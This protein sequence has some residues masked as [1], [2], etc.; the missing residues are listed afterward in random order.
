MGSTTPAPAPAAAP[1]PVVVPTPV[2]T[3]VVEDDELEEIEPDVVEVVTVTAPTGTTYLGDSEAPT[4]PI[5]TP[6]ITGRSLNDATWAS[7][8]GGMGGMYAYDTIK[9]PLKIIFKQHPNNSILQP[10]VTAKNIK[11]RSLW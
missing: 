4:T 3:P 6:T 9:E 5:A 10:P 7:R 8:D 11:I 2:I 1:V